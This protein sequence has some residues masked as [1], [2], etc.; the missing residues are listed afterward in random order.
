[1]D[2]ALAAHRDLLQAAGTVVVVA[3]DRSDGQAGTVLAVRTGNGDFSWR[4]KALLLFSPVEAASF[5]LC[6]RGDN[7][8]RLTPKTANTLRMLAQ[9][10]PAIGRAVQTRT[11]LLQRAGEGLCL[12]RD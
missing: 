10:F 9:T 2:D 4:H 3:L 12:K 6:N 5:R 1:M 7:R 8:D 11:P